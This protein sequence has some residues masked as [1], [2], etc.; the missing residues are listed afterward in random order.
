MHTVSQYSDDF[1]R[2][3]YKKPNILVLLLLGM[4]VNQH[5][6]YQNA[7][8]SRSE[9]NGAIINIITSVRQIKMSTILLVSI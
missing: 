1:H 2:K 4:P 8:S 7:S 5:A 6:Q 9:W 3:F